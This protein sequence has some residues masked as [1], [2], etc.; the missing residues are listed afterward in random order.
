[1]VHRKKQHRLSRLPPRI[2]WGCWVEKERNRDMSDESTGLFCYWGVNGQSLRRRRF[3]ISGSRNGFIHSLVLKEMHALLF[4]LSRN[5]TIHFIFFCGLLYPRKAGGFLVYSSLLGV[6]FSIL[7]LGL[8]S[9][10]SRLVFFP[11]RV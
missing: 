9:T 10:N 8:P 3:C 5:A 1:M 4:F 2:T 7:P 11:V 6:L